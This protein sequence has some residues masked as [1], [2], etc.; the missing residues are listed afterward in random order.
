M[1]RAPGVRWLRRELLS[2]ASQDAV[3]SIGTSHN[4]APM[5]IRTGVQQAA[6]GVHMSLFLLHRRSPLHRASD[7]LV[8]VLSGSLRYA[9]MACPG[10]SANIASPLLQVSRCAGDVR[11][12]S[13]QTQTPSRS[14]SRVPNGWRMEPAR[15][16]YETSDEV[17]AAHLVQ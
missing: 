8:L 15:E 2:G 1:R 11:L 6:T 4:S 7:R 10:S 17:P 12:P 9:M 3:G 16:W 13:P 14:I 5:L